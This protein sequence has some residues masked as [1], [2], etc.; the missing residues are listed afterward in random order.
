MPPAHLDG[1]GAALAT[2]HP[3]WFGLD[4]KSADRAPALERPASVFRSYSGN[5]SRAP[6]R[7]SRSRPERAAKLRLAPA[8]SCRRT[9]PPTDFFVTHR[10]TIGRTQ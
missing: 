4:G 8:R 5:P 7:T 1:A 3:E 6:R 2:Q 10:R 9:P